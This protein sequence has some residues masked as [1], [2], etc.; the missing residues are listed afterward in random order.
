M[1]KK[2]INS[3][4]YLVVNSSLKF[5]K[6]NCQLYFKKQYLYLL[7]FLK[8]NNFIF[9][10]KKVNNQLIIFLKYYENI[11]I[12]KKIKIYNHLKKKKILNLKQILELKKKNSFCF[13]I[14]Y[15]NSGFLSIE[16]VIKKRTGAFLIAKIF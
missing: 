4:L 8:K 13:F 10:F 2:Y 15:T 3:L 1:K 14:F 9:Y 7:H 11:S 6:K 12:F 16:D 5:S